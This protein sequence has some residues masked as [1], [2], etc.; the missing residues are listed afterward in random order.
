MIYMLGSLEF[1]L[2][3]LIQAWNTRLT[4]K[5]LRKLKFEFL[6]CWIGNTL[7]LNNFLNNFLSKKKGYHFQIPWEKY[8]GIM[9][10]KP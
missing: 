2:V 5:I 8:V 9:H 6:Q 4:C 1:V 7:M 3:S 10:K